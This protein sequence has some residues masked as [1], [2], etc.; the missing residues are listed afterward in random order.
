MLSSAYENLPIQLK[1]HI[2]CLLSVQKCN[3]LIKYILNIV[4]T[5]QC[6]VTEHNCVSWRFVCLNVKKT[7]R[8]PIYCEIRFVLHCSED[9]NE[10]EKWNILLIV[11]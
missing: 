2:W 4:N 8:T 9:V 11:H 6:I 3:Q 1:I 7:Y 10:T 5:I